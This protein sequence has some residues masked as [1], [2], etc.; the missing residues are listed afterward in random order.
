M[1]FNT[2]T[3]VLALLLTVVWLVGCV[4]VP[5][6]GPEV[7]TIESEYRFLNAASDL[8]SVGITM[9]LG[10]AVSGLAFGSSNSHQTYPS[11]NRLAVLDNGDSL[12][13]A[14][15][16]EQRATVMILPLTGQTRE[17]VKLIERRIF[18]AAALAPEDIMLPIND[19]TGAHVDD[20]TFAAAAVGRLRC[21]TAV[22]GETYDITIQG[23]NITLDAAHFVEN[24]LVTADVEYRTIGAYTPMRVGSYTVSVAASADP[25]TVLASTAVTLGAAKQ[26][27]VVAS[28]G[29]TGIQLIV[30]AD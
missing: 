18:D 23:E 10:P 14:V 22:P 9:D 28:D 27:C 5:S 30:L 6:N 20:T 3:V 21:V 24:S 17:F 15:T 8:G 7:P 11:G 1:R 2:T 13:V 12:R 25:T 26:T 29:G 4:D 19:T 16:A